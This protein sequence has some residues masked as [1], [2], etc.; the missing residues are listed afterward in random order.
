MNCKWI[1]VGIFLFLAGDVASAQEEQK[2]AT[3][4]SAQGAVA[5][6]GSTSAAPKGA[7]AT[8]AVAGSA[9]AAAGQSSGRLAQGTEISATLTNPVDAGEAKPG[10]PVEAR[11]TKD[12][13][14]GS[15][16][17]IPR[18]SKLLGR[19][20]KV[21]PRG[22]G[23]AGGESESQL[24]FVFDRALLKD[25]RE[26]ALNGAVTALAAARMA[27]SAGG[28]SAGGSGFG[29][30]NVAGS[31]AGATG[32][33]TGAVGGTVGG[34]AGVAGGTAGQVGAIAGGTA[35]AI[36]RSPGA[37]GGFD[38]GGNL[39]SGSHGV[40]GLRDLQIAGATESGAE[41][42]V[43]SSMKRDVRLEGGTQMLVV[44][45][46]RATEQTAESAGSAE[47]AAPADQRGREVKDDK[48]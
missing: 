36:V 8:G 39:K 4:A 44:A 17:V 30:G 20:T 23:S 10:D 42:S 3:G 38:V 35:S 1:F 47:T 31:T 5:G 21:E 9:D 43:I 15:E 37:I 6:Q 14:S 18:G 7:S 41:G 46:A 2:P 45:G 22:G 11:A 25:G 13:R 26:V 32:G 33:L 29:A 24:G 16:V 19:I 12:I 34:V 48:R 28:G 40:F 27:G